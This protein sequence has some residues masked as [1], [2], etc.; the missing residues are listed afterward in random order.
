MIL[1]LQAWINARGIP[2]GKQQGALVAY[3][4]VQGGGCTVVVITSTEQARELLGE[5]A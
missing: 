1:N 2:T 3:L 4:P 5:R